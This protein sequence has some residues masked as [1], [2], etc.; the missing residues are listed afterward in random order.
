MGRVVAIVNEKG[1]VGKSTTTINLAAGFA[2][3]EKSK[4]PQK[5]YSVLVIDLD[6]STATTLGSIHSKRGETQN[7]E[8]SVIG[9][10]KLKIPN[11]VT[12]EY[13]NEMRRTFLRQ[14]ELH[15]NLWFVPIHKRSMRTFINA[16]LKEIPNREMLLKQAVDLLSVMFDYIFLD[17]TPQATAVNDN[18]ILAADCTIIPLLGDYTA[19]YGM[20]ES[21]ERIQLL[22]KAYRKSLPVMG[23]VPTDI[24][25][26]ATPR[27]VL[28]DLE[29]RFPG[30]ILQ[31]IHHSADIPAAHGQGMDI[32][33]YRPSRV[34][35]GWA[36]EKFRPAREFAA[37]V[38]RVAEE[39]SQ[40]QIRNVL[41]DDI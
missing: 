37:L 41:P 38:E 9:L 27:D 10:F 30:G 35:Q 5:K 7:P 21:I 4:N 20:M 18:A 11:K 22:R 31:V 23:F 2:L 36:T 29:Q 13:I 14:S 34:E 24:K 15:D 8:N 26:E 40:A 32:F 17:T 3:R 1:G 28:S 33:S 12:T 25:D 19:A 16:E 6:P 39:L